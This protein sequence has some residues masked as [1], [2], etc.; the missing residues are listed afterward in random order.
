MDRQGFRELLKTRHLSD[1][2]I[3]AAICMAERFEQYLDALDEPLEADAVWKFCRMLIDQ[4]ETARTTCLHWPGTA[5]LPG[6]T[7]ITLPSWSWWMALK[8]SPIYTR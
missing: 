3:E 5:G 2:K 8:C 6:T 4:G 1:E 7:S